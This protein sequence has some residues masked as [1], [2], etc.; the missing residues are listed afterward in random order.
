MV[1]V[2]GQ[3]MLQDFL[4]VY[5]G[6]QAEANA[7]GLWTERQYLWMADAL[8]GSGGARSINRLS[9]GRR[10]SREFRALLDAVPSTRIMDAYLETV[11][12]YRDDAPLQIRLGIYDQ[13]K[14]G[15]VTEDV[16]DGVMPRGQF[17]PYERA[18][19]ARMFIVVSKILGGPTVLPGPT[20]VVKPKKTPDE[21]VKHVL[22]RLVKLVAGGTA[23]EIVGLEQLDEFDAA[24]S[25]YGIHAAERLPFAYRMPKLM[26]E[27]GLGVPAAF[28]LPPIQGSPSPLVGEVSVNRLRV[29]RATS[30]WAQLGELEVAGRRYRF[31][32]SPETRVSL[33]APGMAFTA[34]IVHVEDVT[35]QSLRAGRSPET[36]KLVAVIGAR[37]ANH[38]GDLA[39]AVMSA[40]DD[41]PGIRTFLNQRTLARVLRGEFQSRRTLASD[42]A[43]AAVALA[44]RRLEDFSATVSA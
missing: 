11:S 42:R 34:R 17:R 44:A 25:V 7:I 1:H 31:R 29:K 9:R 23:V 41:E 16:W 37:D 2:T 40:R 19:A 6:A 30:D 38:A 13:P 33:D 36:H 8:T 24:L 3:E 22:E 27:V 15:V 32:G 10:E 12:G 28:K 39:G 5:A 43:F 35:P 18:E 14:Q 21:A 20:E 26:R 4:S